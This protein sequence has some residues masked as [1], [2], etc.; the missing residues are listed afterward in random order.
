[1]K[2]RD[3]MNALE[4]LEQLESTSGSNAKKEIIKQHSGN[5]RLQEL[6]DA[7]LNFKRKFHVKKFN[8]NMLPKNYQVS[9]DLHVAFMSLLDRLEKREITGN[10]AVTAVEEFM[11]YCG[12]DTT[13]W[14]ARVLRKDLKVGVNVSTVNDCGISVPVFDVQLAKDGG[15]C[16]KVEE[17]VRKGSFA[18]FKLDG[19]R[20]VADVRNGTVTLYS[21]NGT[22]YENFPQIEE[23]VLAAFG[24]HNIVLDGEI[25]SND[26]NSMQ[27][28]AFA[29]KRGT[30]V[31]DVCYHIFDCIP[32]LEWDNDKFVSRAAERYS[33][34]DKLFA[35]S[36]CEGILDNSKLT[37]VPHFPIRSVDEIYEKEKQF[38]ELGYEGL[39][40]NPN[41]P[42]YRGKPSNKMLKFKTM[43]SMEATVTGCYEG[44]EG[45]KYVGTLGGLN[46]LQENE[47]TCDVGSGFDDE[48]RN[49]IWQNQE[50]VVGRVI[51]V[52]YQELTPDN[53]MRFPIFMRWRDLG[54]GT[55]KI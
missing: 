44:R 39:M 47:V 1:M 2:R 50:K 15:K 49:W 8:E 4:V 21:R 31:G 6:L 26:F 34:L 24:D 52:K 33:L 38:I 12:N 22:V 54:A 7:A 18:S 16:K 17:I 28:S 40:L 51:E 20:C 29:S 41:I 32:V 35:A 42:Y 30:T 11:N 19:Y 36:T 48:Q 43:H 14:Y 53:R 27:Q 3:F 46:V 45:T 37:V 13:K 25:M 5:P 55:G 23:A 9:L 10:Q